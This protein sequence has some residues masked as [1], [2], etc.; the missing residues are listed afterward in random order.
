VAPQP[1]READL[2]ARVVLTYSPSD[3]TSD[4]RRARVKTWAS[5]L[6]AVAGVINILP[7]VGAASGARL[8][9]LYGVTLESPD[10]ILMLRHRAVLL[11]IVGSLLLAAAARPGLR[12]AAALAG[13]ASM[14]SFLVLLAGEPAANDALRRV[15]AVDVAGVLALAAAAALD[16]RRAPSAISRR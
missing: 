13:I 3:A 1:D 2:V 14:V 15:G 4:R 9:A 16:W 11:A 6:F 8:E 5:I 7:V 10:L 12:T